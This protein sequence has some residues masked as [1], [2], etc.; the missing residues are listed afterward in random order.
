[1]KLL[2]SYLFLFIFFLLPISL[3]GQIEDNDELKEEYKDYELITDPNQKVELDTVVLFPAPKFETNYDKRYY[4]W[5]RRKTYKAYPYA[6]LAKEKIVFLNDTIQKI[7]SKKKRKKFIKEKQKFF[8]K[9]FTNDIKKLTRTEGRILIKLIH[10]L[11]GQTVNE[12][13]QDK[14]GDFKAFWYRLSASF[15]KIKLSLEYHPELEMEDYMIESILQEAFKYG[16]LKE[17]P[18]VLD[19]A[20]MIFP[21]K[22]IH[23]EKKK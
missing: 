13:I 3:V 23:I 2:L 14:R 21:S 8:E 22:K 1:M 15:F 11:T 10:R 4:I 20:N 9:E 5:F 16:R 18:S 7:S 17:E 6:V 19:S 12:H